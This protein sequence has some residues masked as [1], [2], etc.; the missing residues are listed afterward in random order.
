[1]VEGELLVTAAVNIY[2]E[3]SES[4]RPGDADCVPVVYR[5]IVRDRELLP[6][7]RDHQIAVLAHQFEFY[8]LV[9]RSLIGKT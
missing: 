6:K 9:I 2:M 4:A 7:E 8:V 3:P 5:Q 1:M